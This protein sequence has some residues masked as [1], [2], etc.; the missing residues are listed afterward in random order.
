[1]KRYGHHSERRRCSSS[2]RTT[3]VLHTSD[4]ACSCPSGKVTRN[5]PW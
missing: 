4:A 2:P 1:V 5:S 3:E